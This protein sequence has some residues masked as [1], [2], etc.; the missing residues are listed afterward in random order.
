MVAAMS[1]EPAKTWTLPEIAERL[2]QNRRSSITILEI[3]REGDVMV[4][5]DWTA[6]NAA[7]GPIDVLTAIVVGLRDILSATESALAAETTA[8]PPCQR[9]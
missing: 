9:H 8:P 7:H 6:L 3:T 2:A 5:H 1:D 4:C